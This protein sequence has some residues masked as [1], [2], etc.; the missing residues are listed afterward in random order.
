MIE[1]EAVAIVNSRE[2]GPGRPQRGGPASLIR[3]PARQVQYQ[4]R[5]RTFS[6]E[7]IGCSML[8]D[9]RD[10]NKSSGGNRN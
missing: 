8:S 2:A 4:R 7:E 1:I 9:C 10:R 6:Q 5:S 3:V